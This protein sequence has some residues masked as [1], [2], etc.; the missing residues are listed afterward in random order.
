MIFL[1][2][3]CMT[4]T[5]YFHQT[6]FQTVATHSTTDEDSWREEERRC[7]QDWKVTVFYETNWIFKLKPPPQPLQQLQHQTAP[8][9]PTPSSSQSAPLFTLHSWNK[10]YWNIQRTRES[11]LTPL[12]SCPRTLLP[13]SRTKNSMKSV[14]SNI[15]TY[16][17]SSSLHSSAH[18]WFL[19]IQLI[20]ADSWSSWLSQVALVI[21]RTL[22]HE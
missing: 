7:L 9:T 16:I 15:R 5:L 21:W 11:K 3:L 17:F 20:S 22:F 4:S 12:H 13:Y 10:Y 2:L 8:P 14:V 6:Y 19:Q 1:S 18:L